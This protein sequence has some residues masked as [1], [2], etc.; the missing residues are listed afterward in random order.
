ALAEY[1]DVKK[2]IAL[3]DLYALHRETLHNAPELLGSNLRG[4]IAAGAILGARDYLQAQRLRTILKQEMSK[5]FQD[6]DF[7]ALPMSEPA[8]P[9]EPSTAH[10]LFSTLGFAAAFNVTGHPAISIPN[11]K[12]D[13]GL[14]L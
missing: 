13:S 6:V 5:V 10:S 14:P 3:G 7:L 11:G 2:V 1:E 8:G 9:L 12:S 4:R